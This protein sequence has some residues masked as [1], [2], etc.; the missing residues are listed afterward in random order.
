M[1]PV[2]RP[3]L[4]VDGCKC[5]PL[6]RRLTCLPASPREVWRRRHA[7]QSARRTGCATT[8]AHG[9]VCTLGCCQRRRCQLTQGPAAEENAAAQTPPSPAARA[10]CGAPP[11]AG[12]EGLFARRAGGTAGHP[13]SVPARLPVT[14]GVCTCL[15]PCVLLGNEVGEGDALAA[16]EGHRAIAADVHAVKAAAMVTGGAAACRACKVC[17]KQCRDGLSPPACTLLAP[18]WRHAVA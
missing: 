3:G 10:R 17:K 14:P 1:I 15:V 11:A 2:D 8:L 16:A 7:T 9:A 6:R 18:V 5:G 4:D 12:P 13:A